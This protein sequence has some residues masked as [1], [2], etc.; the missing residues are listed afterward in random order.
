LAGATAALNSVLTKTTDAWGIGAGLPAY[1]GE[2]TA[3]ALL[4]EIYRQRAIE[5]YLSGMR[6]EDNR[7]FN[8]TAPISGNAA[9]QVERSRTWYPYPLTE[10]A[11][12]SSNTPADPAI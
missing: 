2:N 3:T 12:N 4:T 8:R 9:S 11:N 6:L 1:S 5:L 10:R 7:R